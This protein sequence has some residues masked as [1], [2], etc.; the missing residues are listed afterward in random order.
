MATDLA[1]PSNTLAKV[2]WREQYVSEGLNKKLN[3]MIPHG[4]IRGGRLGVSGLNSRVVVEA[5]PDTGDSIYSVIDATGHQLTFR[6]VGDITLDLS[7]EAGNTVYIGLAVIYAT[8]ADTEVYWRAYTSAEIDADPTIVCLGAAVVPGVAAVIPETDLLG[9]RR[10][11]ASTVL[12]SGMRPWRQV[13]QNPS[14]EGGEVSVAALGTSR[15][16]PGW[17]MQGGSWGSTLL[18]T[19]S[20]TPASQP[21]TGDNNLYFRGAGVGDGF[22]AFP[23]AA[24]RVSPGQMV[25]AAVWV[26]GDAVVWGGGNTK[27]GIRLTA[28]QWDGTVVA[29]PSPWSSGVFEIVD[30]GTLITGTVGYTEISGVVKMPADAAF[31]DVRLIAE[32]STNMAGDIGFDDFRLWLESGSLDTSYDLETDVVGGEPVTSGLIAAPWFGQ[33]SVFAPGTL[34]ERSV[35]LACE[36]ATSGAMEYAWKPIKDAVTSWLMSLPKGRIELGSDLVS[37]IAE[38]VIPRLTT[39]YLT[40]ATSRYTLLWEMPTTAGAEDTIRVYATPAPNGISLHTGVSVVVTINAEWTTGSQWQ[41]DGSGYDASR[42]DIGRDGFFFY[43]KHSGGTSPWADGDW[44][45]NTEAY[46]YFQAKEHAQGATQLT[47]ND[48]HIR[49]D[50]STTSGNGATNP[51]YNGAVV[52]NGLYAKSVCKAWSYF[53]MQNGTL[54]SQIGFNLSVG[55]IGTNIQMVFGTAM[56]PSEGYSVFLTANNQN[57]ASSYVTPLLVSQTSANFTIGFFLTNTTPTVSQWLANSGSFTHDFSVMVLGRQ[58]S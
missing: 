44:D 17:Y 40:A 30:D 2:R 6:Q 58:D 35:R 20:S 51:P 16:H 38:A 42:F 26:R 25:K 43:I 1:T 7:A 14:F 39:S 53:S 15:D 22:V 9:D 34:D 37:A 10:T 28:R 3:G 54:F 31:L 32:D 50:N 36:N 55:T 29:A 57:P 19:P 11:D 8:S 12:S 5:D 18:A 24:H 52:S 41:Y 33:N 46:R 47:I 4:V 23:T 13:L 56:S 45:D 49:F 27:V 48:G 21:R